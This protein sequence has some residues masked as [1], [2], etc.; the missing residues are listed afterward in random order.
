MLA[1]NAPKGGLNNIK[2][3]LINPACR[4]ITL[5]HPSIKTIATGVTGVPLL[6]NRNEAR[7]NKELI[8]RQQLN[9]LR[10]ATRCFREL[11][12]LKTALNQVLKYVGI[13]KKTNNVPRDLNI[14][15]FSQ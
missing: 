9:S 4:F 11:Q 5:S 13:F 12:Y 10:A 2:F 8:L 3:R 14:L 6:S 1:A 7:L 15:C